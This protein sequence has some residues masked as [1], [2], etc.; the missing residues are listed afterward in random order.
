MS[1]RYY[2]LPGGLVRVL[3][4]NTPFPALNEALQEPNGLIAVG[5]N[6]SS[7]RLLE[8][9]QLGIFPWFSEGDPILWWSPDPRMVL[10]P[11]ELKISRSL[12]KRLRKPDYEVRFNTA[13]DQVIK[14]CAN[15]GREGQDGTW[16][17][18]EIMHGYIQLHE[19]GY[20]HSAETWMDGILVGGLYGVR[21][22]H[23]FYGESMFHHVTDASKLA[24]VHMVRHL[25]TFG[26]GM[27]DCQ[28][29][30]SH[31]ASLGA[32]EISRAEFSQRL[33]ELVHYPS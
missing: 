21:I 19:L 9:Y 18:E 26:C 30:T 1:H 14:A 25:Q 17:T 12:G 5:G 2:R 16:I 10:F 15:T 6:L 22:G 20:A 23:M 28:M 24:F 32:R 3:D 31:L 27:I 13:F 33:Y 8:A 11:E 29:K 4:A 7:A